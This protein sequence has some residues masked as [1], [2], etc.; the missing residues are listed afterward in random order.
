MTRIYGR[1]FVGRLI[2]LQVLLFAVIVAC[3]SIFIYGLV[4]Y[5]DAPY[6]LCAE[7]GSYCGKNGLRHTYEAYQAWKNWERILFLCWP[8]GVAASFFLNR[9]RK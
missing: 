7:G 4:L 3:L 9:L 8:F 6:R 1:I 5:T 2:K